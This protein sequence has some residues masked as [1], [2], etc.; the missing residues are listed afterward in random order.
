MPPRIGEP[1]A[2]FPLGALFR[3]LP[4]DLQFQPIPATLLAQ[5]D[6]GHPWFT[7]RYCS[8]CYINFTAGPGNVM[9]LAAARVHE[10]LCPARPEEDP[11]TPDE[12][13]AAWEVY[14]PVVERLAA[15]LK[16]R[17]SRIG[18]DDFLTQHGYDSVAFYAGVSFALAR[19]HRIL[20]GR[21]AP[22]DG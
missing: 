19:V 13:A 4:P 21:E 9:E 7:C 11:V 2:A 15:V 3:L 8:T 20:D 16:L 22:T 1:G 6:G 10:T 18:A 12:K 14:G 17:P 5:Q